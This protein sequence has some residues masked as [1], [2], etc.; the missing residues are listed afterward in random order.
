MKINSTNTNTAMIAGLFC[1]CFLLSAC[2]KTKY[3]YIVKNSIAEYRDNDYR[4]L[5][6]FIESKPIVLDVEIVDYYPYAVIHNWIVTEDSLG[7]VYYISQP[8]HYYYHGEYGAMDRSLS[9]GDSLRVRLYRYLKHPVNFH[10]PISGGGI[11]LSDKYKIAD[12]EGWVDNVYYC[13]DITIV[14]ETI[15]KVESYGDNPIFSG[16]EE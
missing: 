2:C 10:L 14:N 1:L 13:P 15:Y 16:E 4:K 5:K 8:G 11:L 6:E 9:V 12:L 3:V 7:Q